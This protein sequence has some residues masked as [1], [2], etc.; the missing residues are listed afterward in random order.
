MAEMIRRILLVIGL[1]LLVAAGLY[2]ARP[3]GPSEPA[4]AARPEGRQ[5]HVLPVLAA[6]VLSR[7]MPVEISTIGNVEPIA[8]VA[9]KPRID[10]QIV[11]LAVSDGQDVK[12]GDVLFELDSRQAQAALDQALAT[13]QRDRAQL[14]NARRELD[15]LTPLGKK[16]FASRQQLDAAQTSVDAAD[17]TVKADQAGVES[18]E[19][20][21]SYTTIRAPIDGRLGTIASKLGNTV[22]AGDSAALVTLNQLRPIYVA[23]SVAER[24]LA[25]LQ[26]AMAAGPLPVSVT[27]PG[28]KEASA[29]G[30][31]SYLENE[32]DTE[33]G[34]LSVKAT[35]SNQDEALWPGQFVNVVV[36]LRVEPEA[37]VV[38]SQA[39]QQ[40]Q[41][42]AQV[43][44]IK[45]DD[46]V[47]LR[48]VA[49]DRTIGGDT[50]IAS[51]LQAG[52]R[53]VTEGQMRL[54]PGARVEIQQSDAVDR[55]EPAS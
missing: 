46:T 22:R 43:F 38:P 23:F 1:A 2:Y 19:V 36:Q 30:Q 28:H 14:A 13:L 21:L 15:R 47:D 54:S 41:N 5:A 48:P 3:F 31:V 20:Q 10:G 55:P 4:Q 11:K 18:A 40:G 8:S 45:P 16:D 50:V 49:I 34:T 42:G 44:V 37:L 12:A 24:Y 51:G 27:I 53:V 52:E 17:A 29:T 25:E 32:I 6:K 39:V 33:S 9:V 26:P 7:P 35:F